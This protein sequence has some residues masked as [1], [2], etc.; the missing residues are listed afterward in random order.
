MSSTEVIRLVGSCKVSSVNGRM[1]V[2]AP[3]RTARR[4]WEG[5]GEDGITLVWSSGRVVDEAPDWPVMETRQEEEAG[6]LPVAF[7]AAASAWRRRECALLKRRKTFN[8]C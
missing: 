2:R 3:S 4:S 5:P 7:T 8:G 6:V 1:S